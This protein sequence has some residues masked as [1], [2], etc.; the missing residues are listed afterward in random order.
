MNKIPKIKPVYNKI[1]RE[2]LFLSAIQSLID[3]MVNREMLDFAGDLGTA[4]CGPAGTGTVHDAVYT[5]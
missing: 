2:V 4:G 3:D 5:E 1:E